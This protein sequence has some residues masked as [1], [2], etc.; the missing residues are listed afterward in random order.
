ME[1][2]K[3]D[4]VIMSSSRPELLPY[5]IKSIRRFIIS[6]SQNTDFRIIVH[7]DF[8]DRDK[9]IEVVKWCSNEVDIIVTCDPNKGMALGLYN[10]L[11]NYVESEYILKME[12]D[13]EFE[14]TGIDIDRI[15]W[16]M[17][18]NDIWSIIFNKKRNSQ[19]RGDHFEKEFVFNGMKLLLCDSWRVTPSIWKTSVAREKWGKWNGHLA[20]GKFLKSFGEH[21]ERRNIE[22]SKK[23]VRSYYYGDLKEE[24]WVRHI[25]NTWIARPTRKTSKSGGC[26]EWDITSFQYKPPWLPYILRPM[27]KVW[28]ADP[29]NS[30]QEK[31]RYDAIMK[32]LDTFP[33]DI[34]KEF[35]NGDK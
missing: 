12:D 21:D 33:E 19:Y 35:I 23:N 20:V 17:S 10:I 6:Q 4:I 27:N 5:C 3:L 18:K 32:T 15:L 11:N 13:W 26:I 9:S 25:G 30:D 24:R 2:N 29:K 14:R 31:N 1:R 16:T 28:C 7:E 22:H 8:V 34:K